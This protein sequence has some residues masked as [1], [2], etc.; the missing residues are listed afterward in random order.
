MIKYIQTIILIS[1][2]SCGGGK[3]TIQ[4]T[5]NCN[6]NTN[7]GNAVVITL[8][9]LIN[10]DKFRLSSFEYLTKNPGATLGTD[11][12]T[13]SELE[14]TMVPGEA[15]ELNEIEIKQESAFIGIIAD[16]HSPA[17]DGW[18]A[19]IPITEDLKQLVIFVHENSISV[20]KED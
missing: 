10:S 17:P 11:L 18:Q 16:F 2:L 7:S 13:N 15:L 12:V 19:V 1:L 20:Q 8:Y 5:L 3:E 6:E 4:I 9:Q 14:R